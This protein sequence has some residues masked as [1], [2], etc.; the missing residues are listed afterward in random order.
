ML[1]CCVDRL[2]CFG[3]IPGRVAAADVVNG[4]AVLVTADRH[5]DVGV[6]GGGDERGSGS[7]SGG[8]SVRRS[9]WNGVDSRVDSR[10]REQPLRVST[11]VRMLREA[12]R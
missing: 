12:R 3:V 2:G 9:A 8:S 11:G 7:L 6:L 4:Y 10:G 1:G 5:H